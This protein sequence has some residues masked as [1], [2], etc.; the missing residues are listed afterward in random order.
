MNTMAP[1]AST[2]NATAQTLKALHRPGNPLILA[3]VYDILSARAVGELSSCNA[4]A[5]ASYAVARAAGTQDDD[6][7]LETNLAAVHGVASVAQEL[8]KPLTVDIQDG[9]GERLEEVFSALADAGVVGA[10]LEDVDKETQKQY[11]VHEAVERIRRALKTV[12]EKGVPD[13][14]L[15]ARCDSLVR[16]GSLDDVLVRGKEYL[17]AGAT[18]VF[19][20]GGSKRGVRDEEVRRMVKEL[21][22]R[23][24]VAMK[25]SPDGLN[26]NQ[27]AE[28]GV[29]RI[30]VGPALQFMAMDTYKSEAQKILD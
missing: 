12:A 30:S 1:K 21:D 5:T 22:G 27:L 17:A 15:N 28:M 24:N 23:L 19:V 9:Y 20:W 13:F 29:S 26:V 3:N 11:P 16:G 6:M 2:L 8:N 7:T 18:S 10:N 14:V 4:L 25:L